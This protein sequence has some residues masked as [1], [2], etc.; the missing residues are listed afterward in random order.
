ML[1]TRT[2]YAA[3]AEH[4]QRHRPSYP[5]SLVD[6]V[7]A[8]AGLTAPARI[9]DLGCGTGIATRLFAARGPRLIG[10]DPSLEMLRFA[11]AAGGAQY[12]SGHA[13]ATS[14]ASACV[15]LV[16]AAQCFHWFDTAPTLA[17]IRRILRPGGWSAAFWNLRARTAV[18]A[19]Y[20][21]LVRAHS[22][23]Y[24]VLEKQEA[25]PA[26]LR[27]AVS[28]VRE[29]E[30]ANAQSLDRAGL[31]GRAY[32][33][34]CVKNGVRDPAA[35][36]RALDALFERHQRSGRVELRYRTVAL[37]WPRAD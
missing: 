31:L 15:D 33:S 9:A 6:W 1:E 27:Q 2:R 23:E 37:C 12:L 24:A 36:E 29:A 11:H 32:S 28:G 30:F 14:L 25:A 20:D 10:I 22:T 19:E 4:Y 21:A 34:S 17:E 18:V 35:F 13:S 26:D 16:L 3:S 8:T 5:D 7:L